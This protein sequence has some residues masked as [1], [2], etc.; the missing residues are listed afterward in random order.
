MGFLLL[1]EDVLTMTRSRAVDERWTAAIR[2]IP[3][4]GNVSLRFLLFP[5]QRDQAI[6]QR[7]APVQVFMT[8]VKLTVV[9]DT[10]FG[11]E[12]VA[13]MAIGDEQAAAACRDGHRFHQAGI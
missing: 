1:L 9:N 4:G 12:H 3:D 5:D 13:Q 2:R 8:A 11:L 10:P 6:G 7:A